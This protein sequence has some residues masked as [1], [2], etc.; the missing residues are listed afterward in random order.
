LDLDNST[1]T[2]GSATTDLTLDIGDSSD[3]GTGSGSSDNG[4]GSGS[5]SGTLATVLA[6]LTFTGGF[7]DLPAGITLSSTGGKIT[8]EEGG[9]VNGGTLNLQDSTLALGGSFSNTGDNLTLSGTGLKLLSDLSLSSN[10]AVTFDSYQPNDFNLVLSDNSTG[11]ISLGTIT[12]A[13]EN[14]EVLGGTLS[15]AGGSSVGANGLIEVGEQ[16]NLSLQGNLTVAGTLDLND[17]ATINLANNATANLSGGKLELAGTHGLDGITTDNDTTLQINTSGGISRTDNGTSTVGNLVLRQEGSY[18][19]VSIGVDNMSLTVGGTAPQ[20][21]GDNIT[22]SNGNLIFQ[23]TPS[24]DNSSSLSVISGELI[25]QSGVTIN[26][27]SLDFTSSTFKPSGT[28]SLTGSSHFTFDSGSSVMLEGDTTL[29]QSGSVTWASPDLNGNALTLNVDNMTIGGALSIGTGES[30][31]S[32]SSNLYLNDNLTI[33]NGGILS[34][35]N[36]SVTISSIGPEQWRHTF[37]GQWSC[38]NWR[39]LDT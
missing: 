6:D 8:F 27:S 9:A 37:I 29:S 12:L 21:G 13:S 20:F 4:S 34:S 7:V 30:L 15:L 11:N 16:G 3:N 18:S 33:G 38:T 10:S 28:V 35:D 25:L 1:L 2:L 32:G 36:G 23:G 17:G 14:I 19:G 24:F 31:S 39:S 5:P 26:D 22:Q